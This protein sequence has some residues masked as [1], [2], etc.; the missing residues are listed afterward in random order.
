MT[1]ELESNPVVQQ[2]QGYIAESVED[3]AIFRGELTVYIRPAHFLRTCEFL[4]DAPGLR[5]KFLSDV[6][7]LDLYPQEPRFEVV[8][9]LLSI[10]NTKRLRLKVRVGGEDPHTVSAFSLWPSANAFEREVFDLFGIKFD[11]HPFMRRLLLPEEWEGFPL[12]KDYP[13]EGYR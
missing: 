11:D 1:S 5:Y 9:H 3:A 13:T 8:Y 12:R 7:A 10:E 6:T 4:R 2:I